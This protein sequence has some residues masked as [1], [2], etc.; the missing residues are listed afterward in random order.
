MKGLSLVLLGLQASTVVATAAPV[1]APNKLDRRLFWNPFNAMHNFWDGA[2]GQV[3]AAA[4]TTTTKTT[5]RTTSSSTRTTSTKATTSSTS[6][7]TSSSSTHV[8]TSSASSSTSSSASSSTSSSASSSSSAL[9]APAVAMNSGSVKAT[10]LI[11]ARDADSA[12]QASSGLNGYGI[13]FETLL[14]PQGGVALPALNSSTTGNYGGFITM[15]GL[16]YDYGND[17]W[18]SAIT[19]D[20]WSQLYAYQVAFGV[21]MVQID[22]YPQ[23]AFGTTAIGSCCDS[24]VEQLISFS[25][26][27]AFAQAGLKV[28]AGMSTQGLY[29]YIT[30]ITDPSTTW[31]IAQFAA[32]SQFSSP[33]TAG[34]IN[35]FNGREQMAFFTTWAT[36]WSPSS[37]FLQHGA[38]TWMTRGLYAGYRR[39]NLNA[40]IDDMMLG[41]PI[42]KDSASRSYRVTPADMSDIRDWV[43]TI[44]SKMNPGSFFRPEIGYNGNGNLISVDPSSSKEE[45]QPH[46]IYT[47]YN[48][49]DAEWKKPLGTGVDLWPANA[50]NSYSYS[51]ECLNQDDLSAW[52]QIPSNR[53]QFMHLSHTF[54][55][56]HLNNATYNDVYREISFNQA[57]L[58]QVGLAAGTFSPKALIPPAITGLHNGDA[59]QAFWDLGLRNCVGDNARPAL[60]NTANLMW[61]YITNTATDGFDGFTVI[62]RWPL[63]IYWNCDTPAC[64]TQEWIDTSSGSGDFNNLILNEKNDM[65]RYFFGLYRDGVMFHQINLRTQGNSAISTADGTQVASLYQAWVETVVQEF[66]RL[67]NWPMISLKQDDLADA[68]VARMARDKCGYGLTWDKANGKITGVTVTANGNTCSTEIPVTVPGSVVDT[69][70]FRTEQV[71]NDPLTIWVKLSGSPVSLTLSQPI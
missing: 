52:L 62:P 6:V 56:E 18:R 26:T 58:T 67:S 8:S 55:H 63:R 1:A 28:G 42:Y 49:T 35:N 32:N 36:D 31:E 48:P 21:R 39:V 17:N 53:D 30:Q 44:N 9:F 46:P 3:A 2:F 61:P 14:V 45:C 70:G 40:Q 11:I 57:W 19:D 54:T 65:M 50:P 23:A 10:I 7:R 25:N 34:V 47:G 37:N 69:K 20:Q 12:R 43:P 4:A 68:F 13:P 27:T 22:V 16:A 15:S 5:A 29:H 41:T 66:T 51:L 38:I 24:G 64:T 33:S 71:G 60:R 59:L